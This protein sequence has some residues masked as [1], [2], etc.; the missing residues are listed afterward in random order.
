MKHFNRIG[1]VVLAVAVAGIIILLMREA[2]RGPTFRAEDHASY[3]ECMRNIPPQWLP[4][5]L[6]RTRSETACH[7]IQER[8]A[9][10]PAG[11]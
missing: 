11:S 4:G 9:R 7:F 2:A 5:S 10:Q 8:R 3:E 6:E 1:L